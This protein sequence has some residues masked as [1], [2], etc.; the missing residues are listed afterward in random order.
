MGSL[1]ES[2]LSIMSGCCIVECGVPAGELPV[3]ECL[4]VTST[5][6][7]KVWGGIYVAGVMG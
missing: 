2:S 3:R 6:C 5:L 1:F 7:L 4:C